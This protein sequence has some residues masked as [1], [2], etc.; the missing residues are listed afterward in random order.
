[1]RNGLL[2]LVLLSSGL[3]AAE[4]IECERE[5]RASLR[6]ED[7]LRKGYV[8]RGYRD[9]ND[10]RAALNDQNNWIWK[11]CRQYSRDLREMAARP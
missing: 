11:H 9:R 3:Q 8:L 4:W 6:L 7:A 2:I 5:K 10:M 1:M